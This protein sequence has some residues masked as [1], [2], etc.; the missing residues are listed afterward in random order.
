M[1][2]VSPHPAGLPRE[3]EWLQL[4]DEKFDGETGHTKPHPFLLFPLKENFPAYCVLF[5][6]PPGQYLASVACGVNL[7]YS[8]IWHTTRLQI[9]VTCLFIDFSSP[10]GNSLASTRSRQGKWLLGL[11]PS[12]NIPT[13]FCEII[14]FILVLEIQQ[15]TSLAQ[16][17]L[18][19][20]RE[21]SLAHSSYDFK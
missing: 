17:Y 14:L 12:S 19:H 1:L 3:G 18:S 20:K 9:K 15:L 11:G 13:C 8:G 6:C 10:N 2:L 16:D 5:L 4:M 7:S 21:L